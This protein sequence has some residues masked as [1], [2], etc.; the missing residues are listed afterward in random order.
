MRIKKIK[1]FKKMDLADFS[2]F[3]MLLCSLTFYYDRAILV[4]GQLLFISVILFKTKKINKYQLKYL[5]RWSLFVL[6]CGFSYFWAMDRSTIIST[7]LSLIQVALISIG[8]VMYCDSKEKI[9]KFLKYYIFGAIVLIIRCMI[10]IPLALWLSDRFGDTIGYNSNT[11]GQIFS[12]AVLF[13]FFYARYRNKKYY[14]LV[15]SFSVVSLLTGSRKAFLV[16]VLGVTLIIVL[17]SKNIK[18]LFI[19]IFIGIGIGLGM[20]YIA[21]NVELF[22]NIIGKRI[23]DLFEIILGTSAGDRSS[24]DRIYF[25]KYGWEN[26]LKKP[27]LGIGIDGFRHLQ[28][29]WTYSHNNY[30]EILC[31]V[32]IIGFLVYY[33]MLFEILFKASIESFK[34]NRNFLLACVLILSILMID[35]ANIS[36][37]YEIPQMLLGISYSIFVYAKRTNKN[38]E[39]LFEKGLGGSNNEIKN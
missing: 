20:Y 22:Y 37:L 28:G 25:I 29:A 23:E 18:R 35:M 1:T 34:A 16:I 5:R 27:I 9:H 13:S 33:S 11:L 15:L 2:A 3:I 36:Y 8:V 30:I 17:E 31:N 24:Q 14:L 39:A 38:E 7:L 12:H 19:N 6:I 4:G 26:F 21:M 10:K 32:G